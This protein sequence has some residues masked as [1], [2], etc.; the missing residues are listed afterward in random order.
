MHGKIFLLL[1]CQKVYMLYVYVNERR[2]MTHEYL[3]SQEKRLGSL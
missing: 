2:A 1:L 3:N